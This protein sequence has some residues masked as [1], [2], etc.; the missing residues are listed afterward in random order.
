MINGYAVAFTAPGTEKS[1]K[2]INP[3]VGCVANVPEVALCLCEQMRKDGIKDVIPFKCG[4]SIVG[5]DYVKRFRIDK[6]ILNLEEA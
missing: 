2:N 6:D 1:N 3:Q 4:L 5:W